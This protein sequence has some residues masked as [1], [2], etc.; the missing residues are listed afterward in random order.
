MKQFV[1]WFDWK[2]QF[3]LDLDDQSLEVY[4]MSKENSIENSI[5]NCMEKYSTVVNLR[6]GG[7]EED[8]IGLQVGLVKGRKGCR[9]K[10][11]KWEN[12]SER[13]EGMLA[14]K[15]KVGK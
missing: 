14:E 6:W 7:G 15:V 10:K 13:Q 4:W 2:F 8:H 3:T 11:W 5:E 1:I 9:L 12:E